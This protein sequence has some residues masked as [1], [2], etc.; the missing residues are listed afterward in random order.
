MTTASK[1]SGIYIP[2]ARSPNLVEATVTISRRQKETTTGTLAKSEAPEGL[3]DSSSYS[4]EKNKADTHDT[5]TA[6]TMN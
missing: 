3:P 2:N 4:T 1:G 6:E 5:F